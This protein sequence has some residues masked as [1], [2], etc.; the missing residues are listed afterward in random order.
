M[1]NITVPLPENREPW[2]I[3]LS[4]REKLLKRAFA[5][6]KR[7]A[8]MV[9]MLADTSTFRY[10]CYNVFQATMESGKWQSIY[11]FSDELP[12]VFRFLDIADLLI[13]TRIKWTHEIEQLALSAKR[14]KVPVLYDIDDYVC[15]INAFKIITNTLN[16]HF[17]SEADYDFWF[18]Y[19]SRLQKAAELADGF[20]TT[21]GYL[22]NRLGGKFGRPFRIIV[23]SLNRE[24]LEISGK[25]LDQKKH[26]GSAGNYMIGYFSGTPSHINDFREVSGELRALLT[27]CP[28]IR[29][30]VVGFMDF[31]PEMDPLI[32]E[33]RVVFSPLVDFMELQRLIAEVDVN[34]V[35]LVNN[36]FT[37]CKS[38]LKFFEAAA[39]GTPTIATPIYSYANAITDGVN[40]FLCMPGTWYDRLYDLYENREKGK[41]VAENALSCVTGKYS[42]EAFRKMIEE[43]YDSFV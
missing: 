9:Y 36:A 33:G 30:K 3:P 10:R 24:Q 40:G 42:G 13:L 20:L 34:L 5:Q 14:K 22:G 26:K 12:S 31:P 16:V 17:G 18:A 27:D 43:A 23:N 7:I 32:N 35:P 38:E 4:E 28:Q 11:F 8:V 25:C 1:F 41:N 29:L 39:V 19:F 37:N 21:N 6:G 2:K 15:D